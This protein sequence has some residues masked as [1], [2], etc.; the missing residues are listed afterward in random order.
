MAGAIGPSASPR[1]IRPPQLAASF[2]S[3]VTCWHIAKCC[4]TA[5]FG[6]NRGYGRHGRTCCW[7]DVVA[8]YM[9]RFVAAQSCLTS[10]SRQPNYVLM[11]NP[12]LAYLSGRKCQSRSNRFR[13]AFCI[14]GSDWCAHWA[15]LHFFTFSAPSRDSRLMLMAPYHPYAWATARPIKQCLRNSWP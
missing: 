5:R 11:R 6:R 4:R 1:R 15:G 14:N 3:D 13:R 10:I 8:T 12:G 2:I 7:L 9:Y